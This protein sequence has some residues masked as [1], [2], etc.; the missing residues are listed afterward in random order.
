M[1]TE[2]GRLIH[3]M[4]E[5]CKRDL[6]WLV[7][8]PENKKTL[9]IVGGSPSLKDN[10]NKLRDRVRLGGH[11]LTTNGSL[12]YLSDKGFKPKFHA[13]F[14]A[15]P[16]NVSFVEFA[17]KDTE[18][19]IGS[20]SDPSVLD[21]LKDRNVTIWHG[22]FEIEDQLKIL[23]PYQNRPIVIVGGN[24]TIGLRALSLGYH[25]GYRRF[26]LFGVDSS[27]KDGEHHAYSQ[28]LNDNDK[29]IQAT[30]KGKVYDCAPWMYRQAMQFEQNYKEMVSLG[31]RIEVVG[32]GLI[33]DMCKFLNK[34]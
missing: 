31:C 2:R 12:M 15:R 17:P 23:E 19:L 18:Y 24:Y 5:N 20:M 26:V 21:A 25:L 3:N 27:Y 1:N 29:P 28:S 10:I 34:V 4:T 16:E 8:F 33:P 7:P 11:L 9:L 32:E 14:D 22:G 6:E 13:Q 30:Y